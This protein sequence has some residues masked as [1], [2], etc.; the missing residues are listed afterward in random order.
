MTATEQFSLS[1]DTRTA[2]LRDVH[3]TSQT[4]G[5]PRT[6]THLPR[7]R[8]RPYPATLRARPQAP[9]R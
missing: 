1:L 8:K 7:Q 3:G 2:A 5:D 9:V 6:Q 4:T